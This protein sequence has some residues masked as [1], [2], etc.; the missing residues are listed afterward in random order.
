MFSGLDAEQFRLAARRLELLALAEIGGEGHHLGAIF[1][2]QPFQD[3]RGVQPAGIGEHHLADAFL[4]QTVLRFLISCPRGMSGLGQ[5]RGGFSIDGDLF[6]GEIRL[7]AGRGKR[8]FRIEVT[9]PAF[10]PTP[11]RPRPAVT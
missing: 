1:R 5:Y 7:Q 6:R 4:A 11:P 8:L 2:L 9:F 10:T 3:D